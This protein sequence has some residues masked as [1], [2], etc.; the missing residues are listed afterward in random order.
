MEEGLVESS[1]KEIITD[2]G[3]EFSSSKIKEMCRKLG[4]VDIVIVH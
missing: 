3:L 4:V 2:N 1:R